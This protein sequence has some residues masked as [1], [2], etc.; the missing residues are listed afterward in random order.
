M[1]VGDLLFPE[2]FVIL[3]VGKRLRL[4][5]KNGKGEI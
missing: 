5:W 4:D 3:T 1:K 2:R